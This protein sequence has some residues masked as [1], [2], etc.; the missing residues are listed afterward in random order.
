[1]FFRFMC[2]EFCLHVC[3]YVYHMHV[4]KCTTCMPGTYIGAGVTGGYELL[5]GTENTT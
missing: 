4:C 5:L 1:M 2:R 3:M